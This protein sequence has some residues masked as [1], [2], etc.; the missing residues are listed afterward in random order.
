MAPQFGEG[1]THSRFALKAACKCG[2][3]HD[4]YRRD[5]IEKVTVAGVAKS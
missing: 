5:T 4:R 1:R 3:A 2:S